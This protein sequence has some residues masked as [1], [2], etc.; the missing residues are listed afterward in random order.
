MTE[1]DPERPDLVDRMVLCGPVIA[2][3]RSGPHLVRRYRRW[4]GRL[5]RLLTDVPDRAGWL[6]L[7]DE[8]ESTDLGDRLPQVVA[9][10]L[11]LCG[12]RDRESLPDAHRLARELPSAHL[13][14]LPHLGHLVPVTAPGLFNDIV[15]GFLG[16]P[17]QS[18]SPST[19]RP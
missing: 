13:L 8:L 15:A 18:S 3:G 1:P 7:V 19:L 12:K 17:P 11:V 4:P 2:P 10:T 14:V 16:Q 5:L 6:A 9:P